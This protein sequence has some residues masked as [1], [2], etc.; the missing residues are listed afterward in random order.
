MDKSMI[1]NLHNTGLYSMLSCYGE[2]FFH[3][4]LSLVQCGFA[5]GFLK[6]TKS[7]SD[8]ISFRKDYILE[9]YHFATYF[10]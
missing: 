7:M 4:V 10:R 3:L 9:A 5:L 6:Q 8:E 1:F 2:L